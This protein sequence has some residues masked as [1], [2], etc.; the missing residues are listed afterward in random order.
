LLT[1]PKLSRLLY[2]KLTSDVTAG[3]VTQL[4]RLPLYYFSPAPFTDVGYKRAL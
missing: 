4:W 3:H 2:G 1:D